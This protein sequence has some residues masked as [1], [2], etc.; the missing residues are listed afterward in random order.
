MAHVDQPELP[1]D[2]PAHP[3]TD[4]GTAVHLTTSTFTAPDEKEAAGVERAA[5]RERIAA[6]AD[7]QRPSADP[8][9]IQHRLRKGDSN[10]LP[11]YS[12]K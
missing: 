8:Q 11:K 4:Q 10:L 6:A 5:A 1:T 12:N 3:P 9:N 7:Q 2:P